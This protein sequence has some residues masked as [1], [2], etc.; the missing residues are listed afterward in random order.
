VTGA[1]TVLAPGGVYNLRMLRSDTPHI[2]PRT[3][4]RVL[5]VAVAIA[6]AATLAACGGSN[7]PS[8]STGSHAPASANSFLAQ[9]YKYSDCMR[10][11]GVSGFPDPEVHNGG[12]QISIHITQG[13]TSAPAFKSAEQVCAHYLPNGGNTDTAAQRQAHTE[14]MLAFARCLRTH[15]FPNFPDPTAQGHL[16]LSMITA[17][18]INLHQPALLHAGFDCVGVTHG[19]VTRADVEQAVNGPAGQGTQSSASPSPGGGG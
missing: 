12:Q 8:G 10:S 13:A 19:D 7:P 16:D 18:G 1:D 6:A 11:H 3:R 9:A 2:P 17:A 14:A 5:V 15:G 4:S